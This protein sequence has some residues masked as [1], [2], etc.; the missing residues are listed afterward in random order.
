MKCSDCNVFILS[1]DVFIRHG[2]YH[3]CLESRLSEV[4]V[5]NRINDMEAAIYHSLLVEDGLKRRVIILS[6]ECG[7]DGPKE[8]PDFLERLSRVKDSVE[9]FLLIPLP[10]C[11]FK[12]I[13]KSCNNHVRFLCKKD[14][15]ENLKVKLSASPSLEIAEDI[16][17]LFTFNE[18]NVFFR[19]LNNPVLPCKNRVEYMRDYVTFSRIACKLGMKNK[20]LR[21]C[22]YRLNFEYI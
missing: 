18:R 8:L 16:V 14:S 22:L 13:Y 7:D 3:L 12:L 19:F 11:K 4:F 2:F 17:N 6:F 15:L 9:L 20:E 5:F 1:R 21:E 10:A